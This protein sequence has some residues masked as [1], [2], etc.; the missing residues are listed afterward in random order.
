MHNMH[1]KQKTEFKTESISI[2]FTTKSPAIVPE[3]IL[4]ITGDLCLPNP[5]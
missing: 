3:Q 4:K 5:K 1:Q 2:V